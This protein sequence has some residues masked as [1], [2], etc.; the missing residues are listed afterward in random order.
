MQKCFEFRVPVCTSLMLV[1]IR[2]L[3]SLSTQNTQQTMIFEVGS[4][5]LDVVVVKV[6]GLG[7]LCVKVLGLGFLFVKCL[8]LGLLF[9]NILNI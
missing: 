9:V 4:A 5:C 2:A 7:F 1:C 8:G 6:L 3:G